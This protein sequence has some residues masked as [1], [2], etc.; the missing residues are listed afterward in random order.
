MKKDATTDNISRR[1]DIRIKLYANFMIYL[2][3]KVVNYEE[4]K[5]CIG[6]PIFAEKKIK[7]QTVAKSFVPSHNV[8]KFGAILVY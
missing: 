4:E 7:T 3:V 5:R 1:G 2:H 8:T 6:I